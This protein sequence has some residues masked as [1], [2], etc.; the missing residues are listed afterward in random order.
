M[1]RTTTAKKNFGYIK[2][3]LN[4]FDF[5]CYFDD[6]NDYFTYSLNI[7]VSKLKELLSKN[8]FY[9]HLR[10]EDG[11]LETSS[12]TIKYNDKDIFKATIVEEYLIGMPKYN[13]IQTLKKLDNSN[14]INIEIGLMNLY[15][16]SLIQE[17]KD[18][19]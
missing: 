5:K 7:T 8:T 4:D 6:K 3:L 1:F 13:L 15:Y 2:K 10:N 16:N 17:I 14:E 11:L 12:L 19:I 9:N 18:K